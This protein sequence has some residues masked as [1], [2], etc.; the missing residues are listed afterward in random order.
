[1][2]AFSHS[3]FSQHPVRDTRPYVRV[4]SKKPGR[5][6]LTLSTGT[7]ARVRSFL[8]TRSRAPPSGARRDLRPEPGFFPFELAARQSPTVSQRAHFTRCASV[9]VTE[10]CSTWFPRRDKRA[11]RSALQRARVAGTVSVDR[12]IGRDRLATRPRQQTSLRRTSAHTSSSTPLLSI[13]GYSVTARSLIAAAGL[14][15]GSAVTATRG[16]GLR[17]A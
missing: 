11:S 5:G 14:C 3:I 7:L 2:R 6:E 4:R 17:A 10:H 9:K 12:P 1:M 15:G 13:S 16:Q 8:A